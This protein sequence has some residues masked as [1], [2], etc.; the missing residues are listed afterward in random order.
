[1]FNH[2]DLQLS[3]FIGFLQYTLY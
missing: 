2:I 1:M 3:T